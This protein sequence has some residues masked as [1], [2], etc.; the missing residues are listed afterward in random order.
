VG[1]IEKIW[2]YDEIIKRWHIPSYLQ[3]F[4]TNILGSQ[5][6]RIISKKKCKSKK[7]CAINKW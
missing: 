5:R 4:T 3:N 7:S 6:R 2:R 1:A